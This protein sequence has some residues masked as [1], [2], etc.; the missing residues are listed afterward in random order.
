MFA[1]LE[2][3]KNSPGNAGA[4]YY[5]KRKINKRKEKN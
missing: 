2:V 5:A 3:I 1:Y 4:V